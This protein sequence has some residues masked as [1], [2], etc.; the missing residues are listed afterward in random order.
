KY[1]DSETPELGHDYVATVVAPTCTAGGYTEHV[2]SR[3]GDSYTD[4]ETAALGHDW[5]DGIVTTEPTETAE[6][7]MTYTCRRCGET[8]TEPIAKLPV[9]VTKKFKDVDPS[10][11]SAPAI[12][13]VFDQ[14]LMT[15][16]SEDE[17]DPEGEMTRGMIITVIWKM[18]GKPAASGKAPFKDLTEDWYKTAANWGYENGIILG[19]SDDIYAPGQAV[20]R[21]Q[22]CAIL[23]RYANFKG[24]DTSARGNLSGFGDASKVSPYAQN[25]VSW[26]VASGIIKG[27]NDYGKLYL[28]PADDATR[29]QVAAVLMR[30]NTMG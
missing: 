25:A 27:S 24:K 5:D 12:Q 21:E 14:G 3:C 28:R 17:F 2:C 7:V 20:T 29:E 4:T 23:F 13:Y 10:M 16:V 19:Y 26:A 6:G 11:W 30:Y 1:T 22:L 9:D 18:E 8:K 15:G